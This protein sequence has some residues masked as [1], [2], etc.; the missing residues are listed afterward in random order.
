MN[1]SQI[2]T[3]VIAWIATQALGAAAAWA[4]GARRAR[5]GEREKLRSDVAG[6]Q[7]AISDFRACVTDLGATLE[8]SVAEIR[9]QLHAGAEEMRRMTGRIGAAEQA[10]SAC[11]QSCRDR[12]GERAAVDAVAADLRGKT[13]RI[14]ERIDAV[15][16]RLATIEGRMAAGAAGGPFVAGQ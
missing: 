9:Q 3:L 13:A 11:Q 2:I 7:S 12:Y 4:L 8:A 1:W 14:F 16:Q 10:Q 15:N 5:L 6:V